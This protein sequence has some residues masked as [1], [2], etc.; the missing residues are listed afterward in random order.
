MRSR[1]NKGLEIGS[2]LVAAVVV[3]ALSIAFFPA[4][5]QAS[6]RDWGSIA[7]S[8]STDKYGEGF[9]NSSGEAATSAVEK[10]HSNGGADDCWALL[11]FVN[12]VGALAVASNEPLGAGQGQPYGS[13]FGYAD[14]PAIA[15]ESAHHYALESCREA[16]GTDCRVI[17]TASTPTVSATL[18]GGGPL[19][20][21]NGN[22][23]LKFFSWLSACVQGQLPFDPGCADAAKDLAGADFDPVNVAG[24]FQSVLESIDSPQEI[25]N[26]V[27]LVH[28][29]GA[30]LM[31]L[32]VRFS[33]WVEEQSG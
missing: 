3:A 31:E 22:I 29:A 28:C 16:G 25:L 26:I 9:G 13:G 23:I 1:S 30:W 12:A 4:V 10:C 15:T 5:A 32:F 2:R 20:Q 11:W 8:P 21:P 14:N 18:A 33:E 19:Q 27:S 17:F 6:A 7:F 24:C